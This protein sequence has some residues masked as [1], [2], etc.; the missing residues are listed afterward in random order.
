MNRVIWR[1][2]V[3]ACFAVIALVGVAVIA[4]KGPGSQVQALDLRG[5]KL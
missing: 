4:P 1:L 5:E 3:A 2:F